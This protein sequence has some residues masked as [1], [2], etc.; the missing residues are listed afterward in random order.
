MFEEILQYLVTMFHIWLLRASV[1]LDGT[2]CGE[3]RVET[4]QFSPTPVD[5]SSC[6]GCE[7]CPIVFSVDRSDWGWEFGVTHTNLSCDESSRG[8]LLANTRPGSS[9]RD[10]I[11]CSDAAPLHKAEFFP[12]HTVLL[13]FLHGGSVLGPFSAILHQN[14]KVDCGSA[15]CSRKLLCRL[16]AQR[17]WFLEFQTI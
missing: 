4:C 8:L 3:V 11:A 7:V 10:F 16:F 5:V 12:D 14:V 2:R 17:I 6:G 1:L 9:E 13:A 15:F